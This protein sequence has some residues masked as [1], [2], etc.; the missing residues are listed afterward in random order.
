MK[1]TDRAAFREFAEVAIPQLHHIAL[2][3][4]R[5]RDE[6]D[7]LVQTTLEKMCAAWPRIRRKGTPPMGY[8]RTVLVRTFIDSR[9]RFSHERERT[10]E[11]LPERGAEER[12]YA[13][14]DET[15]R[16]L[17]ALGTLTAR[18]RI[19][20]VLRH[21]EGLPVAEVARILDTSQSNVKSASAEGLAR[22]RVALTESETT[23]TSAHE[24]TAR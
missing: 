23:R 5:N 16:L 19:V 21:V 24:R 10:V 6:A 15:P 12:A 17:R 22:M 8:A 13:Q 14:V 20:V 11:R 1:D 4:C 2:A 9:R 7:D 3:A 18:Q